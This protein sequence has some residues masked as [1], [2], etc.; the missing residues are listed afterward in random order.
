MRKHLNRAGN[1]LIMSSSLPYFQRSASRSMCFS[2]CYV[3]RFQPVGGLRF[4]ATIKHQI[5][6]NKRQ[7][8]GT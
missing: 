7:Q 8:N 1:F 4:A 6:I 3:V 2:M 5:A